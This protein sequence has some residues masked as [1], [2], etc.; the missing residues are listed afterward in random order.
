MARRL[1]P[2]IEWR[3]GSAEALPY[4][5]GAFDA[6]VSQFGLMFFAD[7]RQALREMLRVLVPG[8]RLAVAVWD[9][10]DNTPAYRD[11][12]GLLERTA[13]A[14]AADAL[15]AP[16]ALGDRDEL[17]ALFVSAGVDGVEITTHQGTARFPSVRSMVEAE[18]RGWLPV[19]GIVLPDE[20]INQI[21]EQAN[22]VLKSNVAEGTA[23]DCPAHIVAGKKSKSMS[24]N[25][26]S[27]K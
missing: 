19:V 25:K 4:P 6:V 17:R 1:A 11:L 24:S 3:E 16:F 12:V 26:V 22:Q 21:L 15:R 8:G 20:Q 14:R 5:D 23:F 18:L 27:R 2:V 9:S 7:R 10:L 13:G